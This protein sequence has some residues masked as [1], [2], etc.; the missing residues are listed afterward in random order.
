MGTLNALK[1]YERLESLFLDQASKRRIGDEPV[2][3]EQV[4]ISAIDG[5]MRV[6]D[7][8]QK[9][10]TL[11]G[12]KV[13]GKKASLFMTER[14][15]ITYQARGGFMSDYGMAIPY[16][17]LSTIRYVV[18]RKG[19]DKASCDIVFVPQAGMKDVPQMTFTTDVADVFAYDGILKTL[20]SASTLSGIPLRDESDYSELSGLGLAPLRGNPKPRQR[21]SPSRR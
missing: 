13:K 17:R 5:T 21:N 19:K 7:V 16:T 15:V 2:A 10:R 11:A 1:N 3:G 20:T 6:A 12:S 9:G 8:D 14:H 4:I 18:S